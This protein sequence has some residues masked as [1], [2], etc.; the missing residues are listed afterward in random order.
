MRNY[1]ITVNGKVYS[2]SVEDAAPAARPV[3]PAGRPAASETIVTSP[4]AGTVTAV[5]IK[6]GDKVKEGE[7]MLSIAAGG[8]ETEILAPISASAAKICVAAGSMV[9]AGDSL[10]IF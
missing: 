4:I 9:N 6:A 10:V 8:S 2:V 5:K 1:N 7:L 3:A